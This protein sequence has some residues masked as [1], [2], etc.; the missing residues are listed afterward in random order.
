M[1]LEKKQLQHQA[2]VEL[3][4]KWIIQL[5][6]QGIDVL[7]HD[8]HRLD[9][10]ATRMVD[11]GLSGMARK[12][13][14]MPEKTEDENDWQV[15]VLR[16][17]GECYLACCIARKNNFQIDS[18]LQ[19]LI[20]SPRRKNEIEALNLF[21]QDE[22]FYCGTIKSKEEKLTM[23]RH[24]FT[25]VKSGR[26]ALMIEFLFNRYNSQRHFQHG[27]VYR[28]K[29]FYY[30]GESEYRVTDIPNESAPAPLE[31]L[32]SSER[33]GHFLTRHAR[34]VADSPFIRHNFSILSDVRVAYTGRSFNLIDAGGEAVKLQGSDDQLWD[35][36]ALLLDPSVLLAVEWDSGNCYPLTCFIKGSVVPISQDHRS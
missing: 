8:P 19:N 15:A 32:P 7:Q 29:V 5:L 36:C 4:E 10:I 16:E 24:W 17:L 34:N 13:R 33:L 14:S 25:G 2:G 27:M 35:L 12:L 1:S 26:I 21:L 28:G 9:D 23:V 6:D 18:S 22:W 31:F 30:P 20:G 3:L 11:L